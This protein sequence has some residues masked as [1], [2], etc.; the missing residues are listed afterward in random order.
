MRLQVRQYAWSEPLALPPDTM[1]ELLRQRGIFEL[2]PAGGSSVRLRAL[3]YVGAVKVGLLDVVI[4]PK[5]P[6]A[7][8]IWMLGRADGIGAFRPEDLDYEAEPEILEVLAQLF[9]AAMGRLVRQGIYRRYVE[10]QES[11]RLVR[12][13]LLLLDSLRVGRG[14]HHRA[15]CRFTELTPDVAHNRVLRAAVDVL[16]GVGGLTPTTRARLRSVLGHL[17]E[18]GPM[19]PTDVID[20]LTFDRLNQHYRPVVRLAAWI[21]RRAS[22]SLEGGTQAAPS[23]LID[24]NNLWERNVRRALDDAGRLRGLRVGYEQGIALDQERTLRAYPDITLVDGLG[25]PAAVF[26]AKYKLQSRESDVY[27]ALAYAKVL[28]LPEATL[29]YPEDGEVVP[30]IHTIRRDGTIVRVATLPAGLGASGYG[31]LEARTQTAASA[32]LDGAA[33]ASAA[34]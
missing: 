6:T 9:A 33:I 10:V 22:F 31:G 3:D 8:V 16:S 7:A 12:G 1:A 5:V 34:A 19:R 26:D 23:F 17:G 2:Q 25:E 27:Q 29:V 30:R 32:L 18:V 20:R 11:L 13:R 21:L 4:Q 14:L 15:E 24:M 28:G